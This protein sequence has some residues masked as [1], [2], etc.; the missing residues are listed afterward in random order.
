MA[1]LL[2]SAMA[3]NA[4]DVVAALGTEALI[5]SYI[6]ICQEK[7]LSLTRTSTAK[8]SNQKTGC[9]SAIPMASRGESLNKA[10]RTIHA[11]MITPQ[12]T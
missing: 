11:S 2:G 7:D 4:S 9:T 8:D 1:R 3:L 10:I 12:V 6:G 5:Y